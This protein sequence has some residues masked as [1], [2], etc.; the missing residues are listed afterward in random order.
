MRRDLKEAEMTAINT[1]VRLSPTTKAGDSA[2]AERPLHRSIAAADAV[3]A[4]RVVD[5]VCRDEGPIY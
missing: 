1:P 3:T 4:R 5:Y 2:P